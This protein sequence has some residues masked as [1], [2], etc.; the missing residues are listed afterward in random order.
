MPTLRVK[1]Q[2]PEQNGATVDKETNLGTDA[3]RQKQ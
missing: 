3:V 2:H 1:R